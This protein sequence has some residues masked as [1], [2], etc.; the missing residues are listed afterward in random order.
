MNDTKFRTWMNQL[1]Q[2][3]GNRIGVPE[4]PR[5]LVQMLEEQLQLETSV[6][7]AYAGQRILIDRTSHEWKAA[8]V[9]EKRAVYGLYHQCLEHS[10]SVLTVGDEDYLLLSYE[11]PNQGSH[12]GRRADLVGMN[13]NGGLVV[14]EAKVSGNGYGP[15]ASILE[16]LDYLSALRNDANF[17]RIEKEFEELVACI[18]GA[19][20]SL[21]TKFEGV[22]PSATA[23]CEVIVFAASEYFEQ[24]DATAR[25]AGWQ[26]LSRLALGDPSVPL[27][28]A[29][30]EINELGAFQNPMG[31]CHY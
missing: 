1:N 9:P 5:L 11:V 28:F 3:E 24:Y 6:D 4:W 26:D 17:S 15:V 19:G 13:I 29:K 22:S 14:F 25:G 10:H 21:P 30:C 20:Y 7:R 31:W 27:R 16:G 8:T 18:S 2:P 23:P 12:K